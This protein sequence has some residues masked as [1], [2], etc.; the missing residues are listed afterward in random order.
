MWIWNAE[1]MLPYYEQ[2]VAANNC[3]QLGLM[4]MNMR[5]YFF[6]AKATLMVTKNWNN[7]HILFQPDI[8]GTIF[9]S[10]AV[11]YF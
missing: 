10:H 9:Q 7:Y 11:P 8:Q 1:K 2:E 6:H 4:F 3:L 5:I